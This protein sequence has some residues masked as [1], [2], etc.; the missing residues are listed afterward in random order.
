MLW[1]ILLAAACLAQDAKPPADVDAALRARVDEFF[2]YHV[3]AQFR[4]AEALA[5]E[6][7]KDFF[8]NH[9]KPH[10]LAYDGIESVRYSE[11]FTHAY[12]TVMVRTP[13]VAEAAAFGVMPSIPVPSMWKVE[14]GKWCWYI[15]ADIMMRTPF[16]TIPK[17]RV[18]EAMAAMR[19]PADAAA[20]PTPIPPQMA[21]GMKA[22]VPEF[23]AGLVRD[24]NVPTGQIK[25]DRKS[26]ALTPGGS[27]TVTF[28]DSGSYKFTL[29]LVGQ[30]E[31]IE[32]SLDHKQISADQP[33]ALT[34][35]AARNA[36]SGTL[37]VVVVET[38]EMLSIA[39]AVK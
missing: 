28:T 30:I 14:D 29:L 24:A 20:T 23:G 27:G 34:L 7:S 1:L 37:N 2:R 18:A 16:G 33:A 32:A 22:A 36:K 21:A 39:V 19:A 12:V 9:N 26:V 15:D 10:Y 5:A 11:N 3:T 13:A 6:D 35:K 31:G 38:G 4:K 17:E 25:P 8:Y